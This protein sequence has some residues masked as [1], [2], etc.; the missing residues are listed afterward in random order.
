[1]KPRYRLTI[2]LSRLSNREGDVSDASTQ[3]DERRLQINLRG[4]LSAFAWAAVWGVGWA[5]SER[6]LGGSYRS[7]AD[8]AGQVAFCLLLLVPP[9][10]AIGA[11]VGRQLLG[12]VCGMASVFSLGLWILLNNL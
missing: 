4:I 7:V 3:A 6:L 10:A 9:A 2:K 1:M 8:Y 5:W 12:I 11:L